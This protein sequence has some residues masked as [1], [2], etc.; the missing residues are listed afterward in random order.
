MRMVCGLMV[1]AC[2]PSEGVEFDPRIDR[3]RVLGIRATLPEAPRLDAIV[4]IDAL[5]V[6]PLDREIVEISV[7]VCGLGLAVPARPQTAECLANPRCR[8]RLALRFPSNGR[9][10]SSAPHSTMRRPR[11]RCSWGCRTEKRGAGHR[12]GWARLSP[13]RHL[14]AASDPHG[15]LRSVRRRC[16]GGGPVD[17]AGGVEGFTWFSDDGEIAAQTEVSRRSGSTAYT[18]N[19]WDAG[20]ADS[21]A[22]VVTREARRGTAIG[23]WWFE[24]PGE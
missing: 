19:R 17:H 4:E 15:T 16:G 2:A 6:V 11:S 7:R 22:F 24:V 18:S 1:A 20:S 3:P 14:V 5:A 12:Y 10:R 21:R 8:R 9:G 23:N 13:R